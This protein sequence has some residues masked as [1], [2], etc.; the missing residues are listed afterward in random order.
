MKSFLAT[1]LFLF[2]LSM[3]PVRSQE[4]FFFHYNTV[5]GLPASDIYDLAQDSLGQ[6]WLS[7]GNGVIVYDGYSF[8]N[9]N[10]PPEIPDNSFIKVFTGKNGKFWFLSFSGDLV[11]TDKGELKSYPL[12]DTI[13]ALGNTY[14]LSSVFVDTLDR[15]FF[16]L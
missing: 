4:P 5:N 8:R 2:F 14:F 15:I 3:N 6:I 1:L 12:N 16:Y 13:H 10:T 9:L 7:T 11:Y